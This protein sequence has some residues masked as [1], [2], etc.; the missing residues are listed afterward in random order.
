MINIIIMGTV[1]GIAI[2]VNNGIEMVILHGNVFKDGKCAAV[3]NN[4]CKSK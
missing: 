2:I 3:V 4:D 1:F